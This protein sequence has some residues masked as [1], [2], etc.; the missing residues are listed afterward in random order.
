MQNLTRSFCWWALEAAGSINVYIFVYLR[1]GELWN[2]SSDGFSGR[3]A[4]VLCFKHKLLLWF[5]FL[6][7]SLYYVIQRRKY[8]QLLSFRSGYFATI[9]SQTPGRCQVGQE[10]TPKTADATCAFF[11]RKIKSWILVLSGD[12]SGIIFSRLVAK[13][14]EDFL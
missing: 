10:V 11:G 2:R 3:T 7:H 1:S 14:Y 5:K 12:R 8:R 4:W 9:V 13:N 6:D